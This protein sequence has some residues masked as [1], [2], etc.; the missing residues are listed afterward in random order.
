MHCRFCNRPTMHPK[1]TYEPQHIIHLLVPLF[2]Y[3]F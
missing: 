2:L 1:I 3:G